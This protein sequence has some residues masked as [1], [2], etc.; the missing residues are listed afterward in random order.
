MNITDISIK[1][2]ISIHT[3]APTDFEWISANAHPCYLN[4]QKTGN[5]RH[6]LLSDG[7]VLF[8]EPETVLFLNAKDRYRVSALEHG[9]S[10]VAAFD[11]ENAPSSFVLRPTGGVF[12]NLFRELMNCRDQRLAANRLTALGILYELFGRARRIGDA[13]RENCPRE[14]SGKEVFSAVRLYIQEHY[15]CAEL[16]LDT[17]CTVFHMNGRRMERLFHEYGG[18]S[19]WRYVTETRLDAAKR[20]LETALYP[21]GTVGTMCGFSDPYYFS[22]FF[23]KYVGV[24]PSEYRAVGK[25]L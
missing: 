23:K 14:N 18:S 16:T 15:M 22:R 17:L 4:Y 11:A 8:A 19:C 20:L 10:F 3:H 24:S 2:I 13:E 9:Y 6:V 5:Y 7:R 1:R 21:V 12:Q 25:E